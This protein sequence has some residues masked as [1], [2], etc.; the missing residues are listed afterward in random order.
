MSFAVNFFGG[1]FVV[2][3]GLTAAVKFFEILPPR[4]KKSTTKPQSNR[5]MHSKELVVI[6]TV[7]GSE[8]KP[9]RFFKG[10]RYDRL[11]FPIWKKNAAS[12]SYNFIGQFGQ[13]Q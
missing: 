3:S 11:T 2:Q 9:F 5:Q 13:D 8:E 10:M 12:P 4:Q 7:G 6:S 1:F